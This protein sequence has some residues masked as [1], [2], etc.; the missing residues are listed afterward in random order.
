MSR[1]Y[2]KNFFNP[3]AL[4]TPKHLG[5]KRAQLENRE[6]CNEYGVF[7]GN[8]ALYRKIPD[9]YDDVVIASL[10]ESKYTQKYE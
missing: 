1:T 5:D 10:G 4:K 6:L 9:P 2:R 7:L 8:R 3:C